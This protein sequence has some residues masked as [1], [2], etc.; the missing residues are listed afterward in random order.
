[1]PR[2]VCTLALL[3]GCGARTGLEGSDSNPA[4]DP[5]EVCSIFQGVL[6]IPPNHKPPIAS[7]PIDRSTKA[8]VDL[9]MRS[10]VLELA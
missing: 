9:V 1:M 5:E 10:W 4:D 8:R 6:V 3:A 7:A 2:P